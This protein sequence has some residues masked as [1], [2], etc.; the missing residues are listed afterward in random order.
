MLTLG[1]TRRQTLVDSLDAQL[2]QA[3]EQRNQALFESAEF[4]EHHLV[5]Y[6]KG[7]AMGNASIIL[8][9]GLEVAQTP[10]AAWVGATRIRTGWG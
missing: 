2:A 1:N 7:I 10:A 5:L 8:A 9:A 3:R 4:F 6:V